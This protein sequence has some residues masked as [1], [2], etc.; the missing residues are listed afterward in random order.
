MAFFLVL[1]L[2]QKKKKKNLHR[3][4]LQKIVLLLQSYLSNIFFIVL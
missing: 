3:I 4:N 1:D 2:V